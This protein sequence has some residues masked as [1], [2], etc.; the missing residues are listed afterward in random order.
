MS[1]CILSQTHMWRYKN[2]SCVASPVTN[3]CF[4]VTQCTCAQSFGNRN[5]H[6]SVNCAEFVR[7]YIYDYIFLNI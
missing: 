6:S 1:S 3:L 5:R 7:F 4:D 2:N